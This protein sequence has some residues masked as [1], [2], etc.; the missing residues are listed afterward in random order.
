[1]VATCAASPALSASSRTIGSWSGWL[2][3]S[4]SYFASRGI[5]TAIHCVDSRLAAASSVRICARGLVA[6][7][8]AAAA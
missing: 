3:R 8:S 1:M 2:K 6:A 5:D 7:S 4:A